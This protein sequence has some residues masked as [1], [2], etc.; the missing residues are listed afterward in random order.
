MQLWLDSDWLQQYYVLH[1]GHV[2]PSTAI[3]HRTAVFD[4]GSAWK[5]DRCCLW[6]RIHQRCVTVLVQYRLDFER[7]GI[8]DLPGYRKLVWRTPYLCTK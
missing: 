3:L 4:S 1:L 6:H 5:R 7:H 2:V 8:I